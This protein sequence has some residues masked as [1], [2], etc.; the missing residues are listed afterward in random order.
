[1]E[2]EVEE[3][4]TGDKFSP[5]PF[6]EVNGVSGRCRYFELE[7]VYGKLDP[8]AKVSL[9]PQTVFNVLIVMDDRREPLEINGNI[10]VRD[11]K[12]TLQNLVGLP[13][14]KFTVYYHDLESNHVPDQLRY[15]DKK[16]YT[17]HLNDGDEFIVVPKP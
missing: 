13:S 11:L 12:K 15:M 5:V 10:T 17:Y 9:V 16:L 2:E 8:L 4:S 6:N 7:K 14:N 3:G 1:M